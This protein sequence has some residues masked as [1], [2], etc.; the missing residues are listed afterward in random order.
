MNGFEQAILIGAY[1]DWLALSSPEYYASAKELPYGEQRGAAVERY[2]NAV[3]GL[4][5]LDLFRWLGRSL[6]PSDSVQASRAYASLEAQGLVIR[7]RRWRA[8]TT[9]LALTEAGKAAAAGI[10]DGRTVCPEPAAA[11]NLSPATPGE[12]PIDG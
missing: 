12:G 10:A 6:T 4:V 1:R 7:A 5:H 8:H 2:Q 11:G 9:H 3:E